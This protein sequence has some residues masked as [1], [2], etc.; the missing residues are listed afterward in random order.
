MSD[1]QAISAALTRM[2]FAIDQ[3][4]WTGVRAEL[5]ETVETDYTSLFGGTAERLAAD[6]LVRRWQSLLPGFDATQHM[7]G[8]IIVTSRNDNTAIA[9]THVRGYHYI[10]SESPS[11]WMVAGHY[12]MCLELTKAGWKISSI[13]LET[14]RVEGHRDFPAIA[15]KRVQQGGLRRTRR[16]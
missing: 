11:V 1:D 7:T 16:Q 4:E 10:E 15:S 2:L 12:V 6:E 9:E 13:R 3:L 14:Y 8:P 5:A